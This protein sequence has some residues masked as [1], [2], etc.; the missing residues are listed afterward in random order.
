MLPAHAEL[1]AFIACD[2]DT[3]VDL[4]LRQ[5]N[6]PPRVYETTLDDRLKR[7]LRE[8]QRRLSRGGRVVLVKA[9]L[10]TTL[11]GVKEQRTPD[12]PSYE[13]DDSSFSFPPKD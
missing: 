10:R 5:R 2:D 12:D 1:I 9:Q 11:T 4:W 13:V 3:R 7:T 6:A 8:A